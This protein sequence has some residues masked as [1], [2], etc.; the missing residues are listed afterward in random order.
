M[1]AKNKNKIKSNEKNKRF[2]FFLVLISIFIIYLAVSN[3]RLYQ[4]RKKIEFEANELNQKLRELENQK[5]MYSN[6]L[7][8]SNEQAF[9]EEIARTDL[10]LQKPEETVIV[11]KQEEEQEKI[12]E[13]SSSGSSSNFFENII[14]LVKNLFK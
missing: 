3:F 13:S 4:E 1:I 7:N 14:N 10:Y 2:L 9:L 6:L 11:I 12:S 5:N 8:K